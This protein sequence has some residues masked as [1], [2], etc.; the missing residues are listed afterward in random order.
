MVWRNTVPMS[1]EE[2]AERIDEVRREQT[3]WQARY[4]EQFGPDARSVHVLDHFFE[5]K[6]EVLRRGRRAPSGS[7]PS[8]TS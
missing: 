4:T 2:R 7:S 6:I 3:E 8:P 1:D 5:R